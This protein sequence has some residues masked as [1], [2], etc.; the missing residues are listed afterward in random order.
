MN[1]ELGAALAGLLVATGQSGG[2]L[3]LRHDIGTRYSRTD[4]ESA[5]GSTAFRVVFRNGPDEHGRVDH[6][7]IDGRPVPGAAEL[8]DL[9]AARRV[10]DRIGIMNCGIDPQRPIFSGV[11]N[12]SEMESRSLGMRPS[13]YF[14]IT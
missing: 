14:R 2:D 13:I 10:I 7:L 6:L 11:M 12:L 3:I 9:R 8:L 4:H 1:I 5:C